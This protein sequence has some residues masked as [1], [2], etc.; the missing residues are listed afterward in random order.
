M[1]YL[2]L[3][4]LVGCAATLPIPS[5]LDWPVVAYP[6]SEKTLERADVAE[7]FNHLIAKAGYGR[8]DDEC[9]AFLVWDNGSFRLIEW[10]ASHRFHAADF[11]GPIP[12]GTVA[13]VHTHPFVLPSPSL[14]DRMEARR[15]GIPIFV[16]TPGK[17]VLVRDDGMTTAIWRVAYTGNRDETSL[18]R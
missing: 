4:L 7:A 6:L 3:V 10:P 5:H 1:R 18:H 14:H 15:T 16:L 11:Q 13:V 17:A 9:A 12:E 2:L 8:R